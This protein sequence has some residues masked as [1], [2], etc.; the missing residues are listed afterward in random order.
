MIIFKNYFWYFPVKW[1]IVSAYIL[2]YILNGYALIQK[3]KTCEQFVISDPVVHL[4]SFEFAFY[5]LIVGWSSTNDSFTFHSNS[6]HGPSLLFCLKISAT[7]NQCINQSNALKPALYPGVGERRKMCKKS[8]LP[9]GTRLAMQMR[10]TVSC[11]YQ[12]G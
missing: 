9:L 7:Q 12:F 1:N 3:K 10:H 2:C 5:K 11:G 6:M 4:G 8:E